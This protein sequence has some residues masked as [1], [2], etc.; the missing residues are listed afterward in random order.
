MFIVSVVCPNKMG[1]SE[2]QNL[3]SA[4]TRLM[5]KCGEKYWDTPIARTQNIYKIVEK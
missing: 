4:G 3:N 5:I 1:E 2:D